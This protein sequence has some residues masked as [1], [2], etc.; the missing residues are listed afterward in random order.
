M[1]RINHLKVDQECWKTLTQENNTF[2]MHV[3]LFSNRDDNIL[4][5]ALFD[6]AVSSLPAAIAAAVASPITRIVSSKLAIRDSS[7]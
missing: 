7:A 2:F 6:L 1:L 5:R 3:Y 4:K